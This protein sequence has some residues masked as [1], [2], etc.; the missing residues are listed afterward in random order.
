MVQLVAGPQAEQRVLDRVEALL[1]T[2]ERNVTTEGALQG[3]E[4][5]A[6]E[7]MMMLAPEGT[8]RQLKFGISFLK[9]LHSSGIPEVRNNDKSKLVKAVQEQSEF[10]LRFRTKEKASGRS[11]GNDTPHQGTS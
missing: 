2:L 10:F 3:L 4:T 7:D 6:S 5:L 9:C 11:G 1:P 8:Q